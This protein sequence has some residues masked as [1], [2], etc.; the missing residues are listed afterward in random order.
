MNQQ[1]TQSLGDLRMFIDG[2]WVES[3]SG[4][5]LP[6]E[7][8]ATG[9]VMG[10]VPLGER[11]DVRRAV[12]AARRAQPA[13]ARMPVWERSRRVRRVAELM[14]KRK[15]ELARVLTL[16]Q[17]KP[18]YSEA[19]AEVER[20]ILH[21]A[22]AAEQIKWLETPV[23]PV[24]DPHKRV[25]TIRRPR[26]VYGVITPWNYPVELPAGYV[27]PALATGNAVVWVP[28]PTTS[29]VAVKFAEIIA[30]AD[31]PP[32]VFQLV[33]GEGAVVGDELVVHPGV[34]AVA[35]T[36]GTETGRVIAQRA[37]GKALLLE[38][39]GNG[40]TIVLADADPVRAAQRI[41]VSCFENAGQVCSSTERI[42]VESA[43]YDALA[44]ALVEEAERIRLGDP[45]DPDTTMGPMN[46]GKVVAKVERQ[47][48]DAV[49]RGARVLTGGRR[50]PGLPT[51]L[52]FQPTVVV[53]VPPESE[54]HR[55][56]TFGP[57][58]ALVRVDGDE[59]ILRLA[60]EG[61]RYGLVSAVFTNDL[62]RA[63]FFGEHLQS[64]MTVVNDNSNYWE[65]HLPFGGAAGKESGLGRTGGRFVLEAMTDLKT[66]CFDVG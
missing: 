32:A 25:F 55:E 50:A 42:L 49:K 5:R 4:R 61:S 31:L 38:L 65:V 20:A 23:I 27:G 40:P 22:N 52:Y 8:P 56:E 26:G 7:N 24:E 63:F 29:A 15:A 1:G 47:V 53:D 43:V 64:G 28:A 6:V 19:L 51:D 35:F 66:L 16:D 21:V 54:L 57:V 44:Q 36:G 59:A 46:N 62:R 11:E 17:G 10:S 14:E 13:W 58:A 12:A 37:A 33:T 2:R 48:D 9:E 30:E 39:G 3:A 34:D 45:L 60:N 18:Y 41:A